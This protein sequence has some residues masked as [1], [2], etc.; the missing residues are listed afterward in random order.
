[1]SD[2]TRWTTVADVKVV[3]QRRWD[4]GSLLRAFAEGDPFPRIEVGLRAPTAVDL[5]DHFDAARSWSEQMRRGSR[6]G[7]AYDIVE[8]TTGGR[9]AGRT[10]VPQRAV[11][12]EYEQAWTL[13]GSG[14]DA[15][16]YRRMVESASSVPIAREWALAHPV[17]AIGLRAEWEPMMAAY[18]W[19][20][21]NRGSG[22]YVR[23]VS[24]PGVDTKL[25]ER[26]RAVLAVML[27]VPTGA[28]S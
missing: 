4:E 9:I 2:P 11:V 6:D 20:D 27:G 7:R 24:A 23:Q 25:I 8:G 22:R 12:A 1:M 18:C 3:V 10:R 28:A 13:L 15:E 21:A 26:Q 19:L 5:G 14:A 17:Q 16:D